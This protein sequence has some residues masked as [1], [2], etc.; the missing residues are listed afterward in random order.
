MGAPLLI[1]AKANEL[2]PV[3]LAEREFEKDL[4][5]ITVRRRMPP[6]LN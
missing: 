4:V 3:D 2:D 5:P 6:K 1:D